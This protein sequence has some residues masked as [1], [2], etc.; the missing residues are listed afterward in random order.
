[1]IYRYAAVRQD[2][3]ISRIVSS[4]SDE[5]ALKNIPDGAAAIQATGD[6]SG[7]THRYDFSKQAFVPL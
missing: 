6:V 1:M 3:S 4:S 2:G 5:D 7:A